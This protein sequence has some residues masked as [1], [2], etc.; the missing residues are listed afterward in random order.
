MGGKGLGRGVESQQ[1]VW[2]KALRIYFY[3]CVN[4]NKNTY[5]G[6]FTFNA[7]SVSSPLR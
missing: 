4:G 7:Y 6:Y 5:I 1:K 2:G 3:L